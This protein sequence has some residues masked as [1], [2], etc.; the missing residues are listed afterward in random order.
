MSQSRIE[1]LLCK[2]SNFVSCSR[3]IIV[4]F[5]YVTK[6]T[7]T[8]L[9]LKGGNTVPVSRRRLAEVKKAYSDFIFDSVMSL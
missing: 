4:N 2:F 5:D 7:D 9:Y 6:F 1:E 8:I 3:G